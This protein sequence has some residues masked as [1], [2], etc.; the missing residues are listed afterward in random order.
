MTNSI[1]VR[2]GENFELMLEYAAKAGFK[3][4]LVGLGAKSEIF[5]KDDY[6]KDIE[7][8]QQLL[9]KNG[10]KCTQTHLPDYH[11]TISCEE[12]TEEKEHCIKRAIEASAKLG[13]SWATYHPRT[14]VNAGYSRIKSFE[15]NKAKLT[16]YLEIAEKCGVGLAVENMPLYPIMNPL[17]RFFGGGWEELI[18]LCDSFKSEKI[19]VCWDF[20][21]ANTAS[22][23][24]EKAIK[25][26]GSR[27]KMT[28]VHDNYRNGDHHQLPLMGDL[29]WGC[30]DWK[31]PMGALK[32]INYTGTLALELIY[33]PIE[34][35]ESFMKLGY[36]CLEKLKSL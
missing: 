2:Y 8:I 6:N 19:G 30:I 5:L 22:L 28:H 7:Y 33:P 1:T 15:S 34:M 20:G 3:E 16:E 36:E 31:K 9:D 27:I 10:L 25:D 29:L 12:T 35:C 13:A 18:E 26:L 11:L 14:A 32:E 23:D 17:W 24:Q 21:H 4:V